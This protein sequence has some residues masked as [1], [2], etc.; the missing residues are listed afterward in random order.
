MQSKTTLFAGAAVG[1]LLALGMSTGAQAKTHKKHVAHVAG[2]SE[3]SRL[4][5][6]V[7]ELKARLDAETAAREAT[8]GQVRA[9]QDQAAQAQ[10]SAQAANSQLQSQIQTIPG[11]VSTAIA[12]AKPKPTWADNTKLGATVF[13]DVSNIS[14]SPKPNKVNGTGADIKRAYISVDHKFNDI[15]SANLT[16]DLAPNGI[17]L[18]GGTYGTGTTQGSEAIKYAYIQANYAKEFVVQL[19]A[20]K[21]PWIPFVEEIYG[22][23]FVDKVM[24]DQN[25][26]GN[27]SDWGLNAHGALFDGLLNYSVSGVDGAGYKNAVRSDTMD[28]EGRV[29]LDWNGFVVAVG[30]Y[31][32]DLSSDLQGGAATH[33]ATREDV[34]VAYT[35]DRFRLGAEYFAADNWKSVA[36]TAAAAATTVTG[37]CTVGAVTETCTF[38]TVPAVAA[39][40]PKTD[41]SDGYSA[42]AS[43]N[44]TPQWSLF[45]RYDSLNPSKKL[46]PSEKYAYYNIGIGYEPV[47]TVDLSLVYK[48]EDV[49]GA[50]KGGYADATTTLAP[51]STGTSKGSGD[52]NE[53]G[54]FTQFKF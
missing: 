37:P 9:A 8:E 20:A 32:G 15:Y 46:A 7:E 25:K 47:K 36:G 39:A 16:V 44:F 48:H 34:L 53:I 54:I 31:S 2:P 30:G 50:A 21:M 42:F 4:A 23:R 3:V 38:T 49:T 18:N 5:T 41:S 13:A 1:V 40:A 22:Y 52:A 10:A 27:S 19:G 43:F 28:F 26:F 17:D 35:T 6:E 12:A 29:N 24:V 51:A 11:E 45:G 33:N 14:Q